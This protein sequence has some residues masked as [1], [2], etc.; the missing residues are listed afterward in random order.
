M[1]PDAVFK[2]LVRAEAVMGFLKRVLRTTSGEG[3]TSK[4]A[5]SSFARLSDEELETHLNIASYGP[6]DLTDAV[7]PSYDLQVVPRQGFRRDAY[8]DQRDGTK[9]P[10]VMAAASR[11][12]L[13]EVFLG[14]VDQLGPV[15][16]VVLETSHHSSGGHEDFYREHIDL[17]VLN[18]I[19]LD[20][21]D[22]LLHD[23]C[24]GIAVVN[25][26]RR[27]EVQFD[28]HKL[29]IVYGEPLAAFEKT[30]IASDVYPDPQIRF[31]TEAEH[32][33]SSSQRHLAQ[34]KEL[35]MRLGMDGEWPSD[36]TA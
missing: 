35:A 8:C 31:I 1:G 25:P 2:R 28:E 11:H 36:E 7:R 15:V 17:P 10:V 3:A 18:S 5:Q 32:V 26:Q 23:G 33:H 4:A 6:F 20:Y 14:L 30:L 29:L 21:E 34:F 9:I 13:M 22:L 12:Y 24:T 16:D 19:L 27:Q